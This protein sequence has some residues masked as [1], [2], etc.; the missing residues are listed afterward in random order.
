MFWLRFFLSDWGWKKREVPL[1]A[2]L[3]IAGQRQQNNHKNLS[4]S[5]QGLTLLSLEGGGEDPHQ[6]IFLN[7]KQ[8]N[9]FLQPRSFSNFQVQEV[10]I[11]QVQ[12]AGLLSKSIEFVYAVQSSCTNRELGKTGC[13]CQWHNT[14]ENNGPSL[15][16]EGQIWH[17][18][19]FV[20]LGRMFL[21]I[22]QT[23][24][25]TEILYECWLFGV[26]SWDKEYSVPTFY[27]NHG[28]HKNLCSVN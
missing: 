18:K 14:F 25:C 5:Y 23:K 20:P 12:A 16:G 21:K 7:L 22:P 10:H 4:P 27:W 17:Q 6:T 13:R 2:F 11:S 24:S 28:I 8:S 26:K 19:N 15:S 9:T 3:W 1:S